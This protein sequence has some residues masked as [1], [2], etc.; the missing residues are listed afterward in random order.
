MGHNDQQ[1]SDDGWYRRD[2]Y[3]GYNGYQEGPAA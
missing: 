3:N 2:G 1:T